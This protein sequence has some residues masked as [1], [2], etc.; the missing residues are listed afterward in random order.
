MWTP[1]GFVDF[2]AAVAEGLPVGLPSLSSEAPLSLLPAGP[3][4]LLATDLEPMIPEGGAAATLFETPEIAAK[5][6]RANNALLCAVATSIDVLPAQFGALIP[7]GEDVSGRFAADAGLAA[8]RFE[9]VRGAVE[10]SVRLTSAPGGRREREAGRFA[11]FGRGY[12]SSKLAGRR[13]RG[14]KRADAGRL[15]ARLACETTPLARE[16]LR[17]SG[18]GAA[19]IQ[20]GERVLDLALL[21]ERSRIDDLAEIADRHRRAAA[22]LGLRLE[23]I[24]PWPPFNFVS[25]SSGAEA[26]RM[27]REG[28][29]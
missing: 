23:V 6:S 26:D 25:E 24:G 8:A 22:D 27:A 14:S 16:H 1:H 12:F 18:T 5:L 7:A 28:A 19:Q 4:A 9:A 11:S 17:L 10:F 2:A 15:A 3:L 21:I 29:A 13:G 20:P